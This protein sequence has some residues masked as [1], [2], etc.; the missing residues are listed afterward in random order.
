MKKVS[1]II[2][3]CIAGVFSSCSVQPTPSQQQQQSQIELL[4][5]LAVGNWWNYT[6]GLSPDTSKFLHNEVI[7]QTTIGTHKYFVVANNTYVYF[8]N[9]V[10]READTSFL[11]YEGGKLLTW[12]KK[13]SVERVEFEIPYTIVSSDSILRK[14]YGTS[15]VSDRDSITTAAG[16]FYNCVHILDHNPST[17]N[18][19]WVIAPGVGL[20]REYGFRWALELK[21]WHVQSNY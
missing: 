20:V 13:D 5:P 18:R 6:S 16:T 4:F 14:T 9:N 21:E 7:G 1:I 10:S 3:F 19:G 2:V 17:E 8:V 15:V 11:R 12:S